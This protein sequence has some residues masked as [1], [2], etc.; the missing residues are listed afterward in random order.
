MWFTLAPEPEDEHVDA[1]SAANLRKATRVLIQGLR[2][3]G[4]TTL[5]HVAVAYMNT[6]TF[7]GSGRDW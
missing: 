1:T 5:T 7:E 6:W 2:S 4:A 3:R